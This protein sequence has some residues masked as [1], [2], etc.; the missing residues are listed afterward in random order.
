M[1][2]KETAISRT[3]HIL[4]KLHSKQ[5]FS[6]KLSCDLG[7]QQNKSERV[8]G[9]FAAGVPHPSCRS[10]VIPWSK[11]AKLK[12]VKPFQFSAIKVLCFSSNFY[13]TCKTNKP[14]KALLLSGSLIFYRFS[15]KMEQ[16]LI[17]TTGAP[18]FL[19]WLQMCCLPPKQS[20]PLLLKAK[21]AVKMGTCVQK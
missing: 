1:T 16:W 13:K 7:G 20:L 2:K 11:Q 19:L 6:H 9:I 15:I 10:V 8:W 3:L 18:S 17:W 14:L 5:N 4:M 12:L 21:C